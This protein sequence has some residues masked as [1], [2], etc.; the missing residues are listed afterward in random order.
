MCGIFG[1]VSSVK[2]N[3]KKLDMIVKHSEQRGVDSSGSIHYENAEYRIDRADYNIEKLLK[4]VQPYESRIVLGHSRLITNGLGDNQPVVR[5]NI[6][7]IHN[8]II[9]N[10]EEV[11]DNISIKRRLKIDS[12]TIVAIASEHLANN[13]KGLNLTYAVRAFSK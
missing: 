3:R 7:V 11:W 2:V 12:E 6:C 10:E 4:K 13:G 1:Q 8:G 5:D 9:V